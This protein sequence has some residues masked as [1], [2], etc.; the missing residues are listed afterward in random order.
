MTQASSFLWLIYRRVT[1]VRDSFHVRS[2]HGLL[3]TEVIW[4]FTD[5]G[6][7]CCFERSLTAHPLV[8]CT[9][10]ESFVAIELRYGLQVRCFLSITLVL[11]NLIRVSCFWFVEFRTRCISSWESSCLTTPQSEW[12]SFFHICMNFVLAVKRSIFLLSE[13]TSYAALLQ[14]LFYNLPETLIIIE[15]LLCYITNR[16]TLFNIGRKLYRQMSHH[17]YSSRPAPTKTM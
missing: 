8:E 7:Y 15:I 14:S 11:R 13:N 16:L 9:K 12:I 2:I 4:V 10:Y 1:S 17:T 6:F 3:G 5:I